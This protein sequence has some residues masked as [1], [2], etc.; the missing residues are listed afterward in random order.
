MVGI[1][2]GVKNGWFYYPHN[3]DPVWKARECHNFLE[4]KLET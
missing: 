3:F 4:N 1:R 2:H